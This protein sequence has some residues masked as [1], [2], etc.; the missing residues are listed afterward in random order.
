VLALGY[1]AFDKFALA[2]RREAARVAKNTES[3]PVSMPNES[4]VDAKSI[5]LRT[6]R[7]QCRLLSP[8]APGQR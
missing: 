5:Q 7:E 6:C 2:P 1:F 4:N 8:A 3:H